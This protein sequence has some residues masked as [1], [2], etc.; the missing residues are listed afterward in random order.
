MSNLAK[1]RSGGRIRTI[2]CVKMP[3]I[4]LPVRQ[5]LHVD[6]TQIKQQL[7][8]FLLKFVVVYITLAPLRIFLD[9]FM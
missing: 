2:C 8:A 5:S 1:W 3:P 4:Q 6:W 9:A 7:I